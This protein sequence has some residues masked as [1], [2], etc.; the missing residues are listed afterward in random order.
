MDMESKCA[1]ICFSWGGTKVCLKGTKKIWDGGQAL[2]GRTN[3]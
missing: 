3:S 1:E 2:M